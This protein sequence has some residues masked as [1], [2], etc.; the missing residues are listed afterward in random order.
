MAT[1]FHFYVL[2]PLNIHITEH[3]QRQCLHQQQLFTKEAKLFNYIIYLCCSEM[4]IKHIC[5]I[6]GCGSA[7]SCNLMNIT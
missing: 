2:P 1:M 5:S 4:S 6:E 3:F 7:N